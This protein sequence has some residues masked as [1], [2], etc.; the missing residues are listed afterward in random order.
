M[1]LSFTYRT[2]MN[3]NCILLITG[4]TK[5]ENIPENSGA[6]VTGWTYYGQQATSEAIEPLHSNSHKLLQ[7]EKKFSRLHD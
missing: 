2:E 3:L 7:I 6:F 5:V 1:Q 4:K